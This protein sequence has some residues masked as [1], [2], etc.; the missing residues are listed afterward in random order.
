[1]NEVIIDLIVKLICALLPIFWI[2]IVDYVVPFCKNHREV[3]ITLGFICI[4]IIDVI[5]VKHY[6]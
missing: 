2:I 6:L 5:V 3:F 4:M 1:M